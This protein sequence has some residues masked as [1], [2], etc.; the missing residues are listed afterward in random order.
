MGVP[1]GFI[2][3]YNLIFIKYLLVILIFATLAGGHK[4]IKEH[5]E[6]PNKSGNPWPSAKVLNSDLYLCPHSKPHLHNC[7]ID[8]QDFLTQ[9]AQGRR[10]TKSKIKS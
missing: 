2:S 9:T 8:L 3:N 5:P 10:H 6:C 7:L 4:C 1:P